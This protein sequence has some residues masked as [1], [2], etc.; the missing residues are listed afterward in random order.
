VFILGAIRRGYL[1][2]F[3]KSD[4][5]SV[6]ITELHPR[7]GRLQ[8]KLA[9][10]MSQNGISLEGAVIHGHPVPLY[11]GLAPVATPRCLLVGDAASL[12][13]PLT[14]EGIRLAVKSAWLASQAILSGK[15]SRYSGKVFWHIGLSQLFAIP[16][17]LIFYYLLELC[18]I[19]GVYNP[20]ASQAFMDLLSDQIGYGRLLLK[21]LGTLPAFILVEVIAGLTELFSHPD[22]AESMR[23]QVY[24]SWARC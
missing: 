19:F 22:R 21:L 20:F 2:I 16:L 24:G 11:K 1:W 15:P 17:R 4:H 18:Y 5:L 9:E 3:P 13:D 6:G 7:P 8:A 23:R 12:I 10:V 14:G